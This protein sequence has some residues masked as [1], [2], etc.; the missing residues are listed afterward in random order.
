MCIRDR[1]SD[2]DVNTYANTWLYSNNFPTKEAYEVLRT[3]D[4]MNSYLALAS[5]RRRPL[6]SKLEKFSKLMQG[7]YNPYLVREAIEQL[8]PYSNVPDVGN[9]FRKAIATRD[10]QLISPILTLGKAIPP[11][12][13][14]DLRELLAHNSYQLQYEVL[15]L[16][17]NNFEEHKYTYLEMTKDQQGDNLSNVRLLWLLLALNTEGFSKEQYTSFYNELSAYTSLNAPVETRVKAFE[18]LNLIKNFSDESLRNLVV[19]TQHPNW[20]FNRF[21]TRLITEIISDSEIK[22][23]LLRINGELPQKVK[24]ILKEK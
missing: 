15:Y 21:S 4:F 23:R 13:E 14:P 8:L 19:A 24:N 1:Y 7:V 2:I 6:F 9:L 16:L 12:L 22:K 18:C 20:R 10:T 17:W 5:E 3:S 11:A